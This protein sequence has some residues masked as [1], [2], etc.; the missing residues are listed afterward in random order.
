MY[1]SC[2]CPARIW[3]VSREDQPRARARRPAP[4]AQIQQQRN[5][6]QPGR[7]AELVDVAGLS[8]HE[9][10]ER[11]RRTAD[12]PGHPPKPERDPREGVHRHA[13]EPDVPQEVRGVRVRHVQNGEQPGA[14]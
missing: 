2:G 1:T 11:E 10:A 4:Q 3:S 13:G 8:V 5:G 9:P 6:R 14:G 12:H 7:H